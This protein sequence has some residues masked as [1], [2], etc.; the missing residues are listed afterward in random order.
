MLRGNRQRLQQAGFVELLFDVVF[1]FA[2]TR[3]S[4]RLVEHFDWRGFYTTVLLFLAMWWVWYRTAWTTNR[5]DP[6]RPV[7]QWLVIGIM[8]ASLLMAAALPTAFRGRGVVFASIYVA[9]LVLR[10][11]LLVLLNGNRSARLIS[12]RILFWA[13]L[14]AIPWMVGLF[15]G[16]PGRIAWW[17]LA[18]VLQYA[19]DLL[20]L[21]TPGLGPLQ[22]RGRSV[23]EEHLTERYRQVLIIA[24]GEAILISGIQFSPYAFQAERTAEFLVSFAVTVLMWRTYFSHAGLLLPAAIASSRRPVRVGELASYSHVV[25]VI[26]VGLSGVGDKLVISDPSA[27]PGLAQILVIFGGP[28][29]FLVGRGMLDYLTFSHVSWSL[30]IGILV[31]A[32]LTPAALRLPSILVYVVPAVVLAGIAVADM[33]T[34]RR[35]PGEPGA[36][37]APAG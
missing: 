8:L 11:L 17:T 25:M 12:I 16:V 29:L 28:A 7:I 21:W 9:V 26:G 20:R 2:F 15:A 22:P 36:P 19:G 6:N 4:Q 34:A 32:A 5:Y 37:P 31:L 35:L 13:A 18:V 33:L 27:S 24:F 23:A 30:P 10:P 14:S 1:V 3:L